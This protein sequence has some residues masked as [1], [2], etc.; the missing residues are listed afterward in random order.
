MI[1]HDEYIVES[2][3]QRQNKVIQFIKWF[4]NKAKRG[5]SRINN[6]L[7]RYLRN[8]GVVEYNTCLRRIT[9]FYIVVTLIDVTLFSTFYT[10]IYVLKYTCLK[11]F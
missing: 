1:Y 2:F 6:A 4:T 5:L 3:Q 11:H 9:V 8:Q 10:K 7:R